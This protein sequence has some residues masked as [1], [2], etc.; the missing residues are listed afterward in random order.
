MALDVSYTFVTTIDV[1]G[2]IIAF[3]TIH[4][5]INHTIPIHRL[6]LSHVMVQEATVFK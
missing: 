3:N 2:V 1:G 5:R 6:Q 4:M